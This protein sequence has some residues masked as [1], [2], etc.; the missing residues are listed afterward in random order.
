MIKVLGKY[1][2][3]FGQ[4]TKDV[5]MGKSMY[6]AAVIIK[7]MH[8]LDVDTDVF[9]EEKKNIALS[10]YDE[11]LDFMPGFLSLFE[12]LKNRKV[13]TCI[14]TAS[15]EELMAA[16]DKNLNLT[17]LFYGNVV[18]NQPPLKSKPAPDIFLAAAE[19]LGVKPEECVVIEDSPLG[20][21]AALAAGMK[22]IGL[23]GSTTQENLKKA[24]L[25][26]DGLDRLNHNVIG[27]LGLI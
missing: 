1:G 21:D 13:K 20:V 10:L 25:I 23:V 9:S 18:F 22:C 27:L 12:S 5:C 14:A 2:A 11:K 26:V 7:K 15:D 16:V 17:D 3:K 19:R 6:E 24:D 4:E 8:N